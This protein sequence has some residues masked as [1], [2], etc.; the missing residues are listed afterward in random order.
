VLAALLRCA[1]AVAGRRAGA[2]RRRAH[3]ARKVMTH[4]LIVQ[5]GAAAWLTNRSAKGLRAA[6]PA[7]VEASCRGGRRTGVASFPVHAGVLTSLAIRVSV[8]AS[9]ASISNNSR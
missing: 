6:G 8:N 1:P 2:A 7:S 3:P 4:R 9:A 5:T